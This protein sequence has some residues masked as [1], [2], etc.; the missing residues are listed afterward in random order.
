MRGLVAVQNV[1]EVFFNQGIDFDV[2]V[3]TS[4]VGFRQT[5]LLFAFPVFIVIAWL[6]IAVK[7]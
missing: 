4:F 2:S 6:F 1:K 3:R 5:W 7:L